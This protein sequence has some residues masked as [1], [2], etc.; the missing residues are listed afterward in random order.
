MGL[1]VPYVRH[2]H[3]S[4]GPSSPATQTAAQGEGGPP[5]ATA[6]PLHL[7]SH[8]CPLLHR[9]RQLR[10]IFASWTGLI[11]SELSADNADTVAAPIERL[12]P[13][14]QGRRYPSVAIERVTRNGTPSRSHC[15]ATPV[16]YQKPGGKD[17]Q[18]IAVKLHFVAWRCPRG[19]RDREGIL[20]RD[21]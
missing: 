14:R 1:R 20:R 9:L 15:V 11:P 6:R 17:D 10:L 13:A 5:H 3:R 7:P 19:D 4:G 21:P 18:S 2:P 16:G 12:T 8:T